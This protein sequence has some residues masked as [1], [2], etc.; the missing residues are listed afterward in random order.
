MNQLKTDDI[1]PQTAAFVIKLAESRGFIIDNYYRET[2]TLIGLVL[3]DKVI[4]PFSKGDKEHFKSLSHYK[5]ISIEKFTKS[6]N[7]IQNN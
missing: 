4:Y 3:S 2:P 1:N 7:E 5:S 6:I